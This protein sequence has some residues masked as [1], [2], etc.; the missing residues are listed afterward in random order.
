MRLWVPYF[1]LLAT[2]LSQAA[3]PSKGFLDGIVVNAITGEPMPGARLKL[4]VQQQSGDALYARP[5]AEGHFR[6]AGLDPKVYSL[7]VESPGFFPP[8]ATAHRGY[9][10]VDLR[11]PHSNEYA[12]GGEGASEFQIHTAIDDDGSPHVTVRVAMTP[13]SEVS[14]RVT[15]P[16]GAPMPGVHVRAYMVRPVQKTSGN[17][18]VFPLLPDGQHELYPLNGVATS[19]SG[20]FRIAPLTPGSYYL[21]VQADQS[22]IWRKAYRSTYFPQAIDLASAKPVELAVGQH[23]Q[24]DIRVAS[25]AGVHVAGRVVRP[26]TAQSASEEQPSIDMLL[27]PEAVSPYAYPGPSVWAKGSDEFDFTGVLPGKYTFMA[28][29][30]RNVFSPKALSGVIK[31]LEVGDGGL[32]GLTLELQPVPDLAGEVVFRDGCTP[33]S[34]QVSLRGGFSPRGSYEVQAI[35]GADGKFVLT[36]LYP[37]LL[38][39][40]ATPVGA[41]SGFSGSMRLGNREVSSQFEYPLAAPEDLR[42]TM[43]CNE[44]RRSK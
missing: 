8:G 33:R 7:S 41:G 6:F 21:F 9:G 20:E 38:R 23:A 36:G 5:D 14:G 25:V 29:L 22:T 39:V 13:C 28:V 40:T 31:Q 32:L 34:V 24:A 37:G 26:V 30:Y 27:V 2:G 42:I 44:S 1:I 15:D 43:D 11:L 16:N 10:T 12:Y 4:A 3:P 18:S 19:D 35:A 17:P